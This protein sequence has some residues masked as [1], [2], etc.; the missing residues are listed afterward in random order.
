MNRL[1]LLAV[2]VFVGW[3]LHRERMENAIVDMLSEEVDK[4]LVTIEKMRE[5]INA[6]RT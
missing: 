3:Y 4:A 6:K 5:R 2:G 1:F